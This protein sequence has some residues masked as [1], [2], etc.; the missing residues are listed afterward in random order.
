MEAALS[1]ETLAS[2]RN[3]TQCRKPESH[4]LDLQRSENLYIAFNRHTEK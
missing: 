2:Y 4:E 1:S 3:S